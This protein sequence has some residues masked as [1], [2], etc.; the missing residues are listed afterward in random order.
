M[1]ALADIVP[2]Y[3]HEHRPR[4]A[5]E[6]DYF[7]RQSSLL[8]AIKSAA[9]AEQPNGRRHP[10]QRRLK[11]KDLRAARS[12]L[13]AAA[14]VE[15]IRACGDFDEVLKLVGLQVSEIWKNAE[16]YV[17][18]TALRISAHKGVSPDRVYLHRGTRIGA[19]ELG[20]DT[21]RRSIPRAEF[22]EELSRLEPHEIED[23]LCIYKGAMSP[24]GS[25]CRAVARG[26]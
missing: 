22:P 18:D 6:L 11:A 9:G 5:A 12:S 3:I 24:D 19:K 10:H 8:A 13:T 17:Y 7:R 26:C 16:L 1:N 15:Q 23:C 14:I 25:S 2:E 4:I 20:F 21:N